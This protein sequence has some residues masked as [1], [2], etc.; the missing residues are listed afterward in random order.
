MSR[1]VQNIVSATRG[2]HLSMLGDLLLLQVCGKTLS[3]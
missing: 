2:D 3:K 1:K